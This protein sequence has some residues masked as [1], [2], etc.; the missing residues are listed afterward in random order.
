DVRPLR[1]IHNYY[2]VDS[3][4]AGSQVVA[5]FPSAPRIDD[6]K[7]EMPYMVSMDYGAGK[8]FYLGSA[9]SYRL[10]GYSNLFHERFWIK[11]ARFVSA[12][13]TPQKRYG[14]MVLPPSAA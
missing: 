5:T 7:Q 11:L 1:G 3:L 8:S 14:R 6:G 13:N 10:R 4:K 12:G 2:P 9:E